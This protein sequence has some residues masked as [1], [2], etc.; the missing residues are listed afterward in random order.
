MKVKYVDQ[1]KVNEYCKV[2]ARL[3]ELDKRRLVLK[4]DLL[5]GFKAGRLCPTGGPFIVEP[6]F[7]SR[8]QIS[9]QE[10]LGDLFKRIARKYPNLKKQMLEQWRNGIKKIED[11]APKTTIEKL[12]PKVNPKYKM[13]K[14]EGE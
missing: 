2:N 10:D 14:S 3:D 13:P 7:S 4:D 1:D 9:W 11:D 6:S 12:L 5:K 8:R